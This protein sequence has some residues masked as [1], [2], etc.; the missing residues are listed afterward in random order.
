MQI[1]IKS[2]RVIKEGFQKDGT[3]P[4]KWVSVTADD[5]SAKGTEYT[6]FDSGV[7]KLGPGSVIDIGEVE[8][9]EGKLKFKKVVNVISETAAAV[10]PPAPGP[11]SNGFPD[12]SKGDWAEKQRIEHASFEAQ[13]AFKGAI[14]LLSTRGMCEE[15]KELIAAALAW[16]IKKLADGNLAEA[17]GSM[18]HIDRPHPEGE[19]G[20]RTFKNPGAFFTAMMENGYK[21]ADVINELVRL[22]LIESDVDLPKLDLTVAWEAINSEIKPEDIPF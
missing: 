11:S 13:T 1:T 4:Y 10:T 21:R 6:T 5:G 12:M 3:T 19:G 14:E 2:L 8:I 22:K 16:G 9:K 7:L 20:S 15:G 18:P 17:L